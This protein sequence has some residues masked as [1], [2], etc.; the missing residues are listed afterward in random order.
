MIYVVPQLI[1]FLSTMGQELPLQ[2]R[3]LIWTSAFL[4]DYWYLILAAPLAAGIA[5]WTATN[6]N[7]VFARRLDGWKLQVPII[8]PILKK[9]IVTRVCNVFSIMYSSGITVLDCIRT[10]EDVADNKAVQQ[11]IRDAGRMIADGGGISASF[12]ATKLFPPLVVRML[13]VG[14]NTGALEEALSNVNYFYTRDVRESV[15]RL[16]A[17]ILP[18]ITVVLGGLILWI[19]AAV[20]GPIYDLFTQIKF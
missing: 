19:M 16:Q 13:R 7:P 9:I 15:D 11:A 10:C 8:G 3:A 17:M 2:T 18:G 1:S 4:V 20:L 6:S 12:A 14:E 5:L